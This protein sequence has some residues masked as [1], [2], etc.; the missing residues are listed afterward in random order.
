MIVRLHATHAGEPDLG[1]YAVRR[2][3]LTAG[4]VFDGEAL[5]GSNMHLLLPSPHHYVL[6]VED[7]PQVAP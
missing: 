7:E 6:V 1:P 2:F 3:M 4:I 5:N